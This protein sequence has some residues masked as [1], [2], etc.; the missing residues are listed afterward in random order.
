MNRLTYTILWHC[1]VDILIATLVAGGLFWF[2]GSWELAALAWLL[3]MA[4]TL[5]NS[6]NTYFSL[7]RNPEYQKDVKDK[8]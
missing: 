6:S 8:H 2:L 5:H 3:V 1:V 7:R 4:G